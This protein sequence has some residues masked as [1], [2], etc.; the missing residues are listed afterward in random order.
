MSN[1]TPRDT[2]LDLVEQAEMAIRQL[3]L[4][5]HQDEELLTAVQRRIADN[6]ERLSRIELEQRAARRAIDVID[7]VAL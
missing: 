7:G 2:F 6:R 4:D 1:P 5:I 3:D